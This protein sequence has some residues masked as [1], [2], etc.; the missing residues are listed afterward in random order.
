VCRSRGDRG[1][2]YDPIFI[3]DGETETFGGRDPD[4]KR[5]MSHR[6]RAFAQLAAVAMPAE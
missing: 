2:G 4:R 6:A 5:G 3:A 1:C